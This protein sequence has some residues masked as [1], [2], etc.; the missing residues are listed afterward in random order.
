MF[1]LREQDT[2]VIDAIYAVYGVHVPAAALEPLAGS[3]AITK[4]GP[5]VVTLTAPNLYSGGN[6][7]GTQIWGDG[8]TANGFPPGVPSDVIN[9][10]AT[11]LKIAIQVRK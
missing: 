9:P 7:G 5:G 8:N 3:F 6:P 1:N 11:K 10:T 4:T 2:A